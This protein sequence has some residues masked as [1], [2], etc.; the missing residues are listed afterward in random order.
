MLVISVFK[1][2]CCTM[3]TNMIII[4]VLPA[5]SRGAIETRIGNPC[6]WGLLQGAVKI[7]MLP[8]LALLYCKKFG[9]SDLVVSVRFGD[10]PRVTERLVQ[11]PKKTRFFTSVY[12]EAD[13]ILCR[14]GVLSI[15]REFYTEAGG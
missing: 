1:H 15:R 13:L 7:V 11:C 10:A 12:P 6:L 14:C 5:A 8:C 3:Y 9:C 4:I 2:R